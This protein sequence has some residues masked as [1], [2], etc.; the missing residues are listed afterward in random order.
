MSDLT[1]YQSIGQYC[2][3]SQMF[4]A[5]GGGYM[6]AVTDFG[7]DFSSI[8]PAVGARFPDVVLP[9]QYGKTLHL[10]QARAGRRALIVFYR[11][12]AW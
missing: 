9:D 11:S 1:S 12:A 3:P 2:C 4:S 5:K 10:H 7:I 6:A 8:G